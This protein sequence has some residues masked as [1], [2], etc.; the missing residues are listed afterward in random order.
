LPRAAVLA[1]H[2]EGGA[3]MTGAELKRQDSERTLAET[4]AGKAAVDIHAADTA[5]RVA[6]RI[7][8]A[9]AL[10]KA[11]LGKLDAQCE[12]AREYRTRFPLGINQ[13]TGLASTGQGSNDL[14]R[15]DWCKSFGFAGR[16]V[17][18]WCELLDPEQYTKK[19]N[20]IFKRCWEL[21]ELWQ[22]AN[23]SS[24]S[25]EWY[26]P[27]RYLEAAREVLGAIDLD[28]AS[29]DQANSF[30]RAE[31]IFTAQDNGL[32]QS[33]HG[34][35]FMNPPYGKTQDNGSLAGAFCNKAIQEYEAGNVEA[36]IILVNSLHSQSW[37]A[38]LYQF[39]VCL[40]DHRVQFIS[41][42]GEPNKNPTFQNI[43]IYLGRDEQRFARVFGKFGYVLRKIEVRAGETWD[44]MWTRPF[45][46]TDA[47]R[48][49]IESGGAQ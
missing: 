21:A 29:N 44:Q 19:K 45:A 42:D 5:E 32:E 20:T 7:K 25:I 9:S 40:V 23:Y 34:R 3:A 37:Q 18:R 46:D 13:Y 41:G 47:E 33:W 16:T 1:A 4:R 49:E 36:G 8:D 11:L 35:F 15:E 14:D 30:V 22:A 27:A 24:E 2:A 39:P 12:F 17:R 43:F 31:T 28:P 6:T 26:T 10:E 48:Q 38:P